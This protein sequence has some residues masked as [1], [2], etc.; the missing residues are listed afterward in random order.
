MPPH[1]F[2]IGRDFLD[3]FLHAAAVRFQLRLA[4]A[5]AHADAPGLPGKM[6]PEPR[7][8]R[9]QMLQLR[10]LHLQLAL[11]RAGAQGEYVKNK[12]GAIQDFAGEDLLEIARLRGRQLLVEHRRVDVVGPA[13]RGVFRRLPR[14][15][16]RPRHRRLELLHSG[17]HDFRAGGAGQFG[18]FLERFTGFK[19]RT[20]FQFHTDQEDPLGA[21]GRRNESFQ[22]VVLI[23]TLAA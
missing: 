15:N 6:P 7:Q 1:R 10:Q 9:Q 4:F 20:R 16:K 19:T 12:G 21:F 22:C 2:E 8:P 3:P 14:P 5:A 13:K 17:P 23:Q 18:Q 11:A